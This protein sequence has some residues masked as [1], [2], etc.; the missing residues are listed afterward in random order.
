MS[1]LFILSVC[2]WRNNNGLPP[3]LCGGWGRGLKH[4]LIWCAKWYRNKSSTR[5]EFGRAGESALDHQRPAP[6]EALGQPRFCVGELPLLRVSSTLA[7]DFMQKSCC[8]ALLMRYSFLAFLCFIELQ[9]LSFTWNWYAESFTRESK[10]RTKNSQKA[11]TVV[12]GIKY[13]E[14]HRCPTSAAPCIWRAFLAEIIFARLTIRIIPYFHLRLTSCLRDSREIC[15]SLAS[16]I[17]EC[18]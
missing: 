17:H 1:V 12:S 9:N 18:Y 13:A 4:L 2:G 7:P 14:R 11:W 3:K 8:I 10:G 5:A 6:Y 16:N 15:T